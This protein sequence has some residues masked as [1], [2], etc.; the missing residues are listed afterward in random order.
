MSLGQTLYEVRKLIARDE[1]WSFTRVTFLDIERTEA[2]IIIIGLII[3]GAGLYIM[4]PRPP[5]VYN[6]DVELND[7]SFRFIGILEATGDSNIHSVRVEADPTSM[8]VILRCGG[9]DFDI[10][11]GFGFEPTELDYVHRG[12][13]VGGEDFTLNSIEEG[14]WHF[15]V[16]SYS[17]AGQYELLID[18][19]Y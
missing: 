17:G 18:I 12:F 6:T 4:M 2:M 14:I 15:M 7:G 1:L 5:V 19:A 11:L 16:H 10:Y 13:D 8:H 9:N 3:G